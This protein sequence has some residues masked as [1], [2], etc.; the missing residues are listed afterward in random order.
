MSRVNKE[1]LLKS[2]QR[3]LS[4]GQHQKALAEYR[5]ILDGWP[6]DD[7]IRLKIAELCERLGRC[8]EAIEEYH[9]VAR[10]FSDKGFYTRAIAVLTRVVSMNPS[11]KDVHLELAE[12]YQ[13]LGRI[14][15]SVRHYQRAA[16]IEQR[17][18]EKRQSIDILRKISDLEPANVDKR[19]EVAALYYK[20][21]FDDSGYERYVETISE[22]APDSQELLEVTQ[23]MFKVA[24]R[25]HRLRLKLAEVHLARKEPK[26]ALEVLDA[27]IGDQRT[28]RTVE[29]MAKAKGDAEETEDA[30]K[31]L[32]EAIELYKSD[33]NPAKRRELTARLVELSA[34][35]APAEGVSAGGGSAPAEVAPPAS[36]ES[37]DDSPADDGPAGETPEPAPPAAQAEEAAPPPVPAQAPEDEAPPLVI[38]GDELSLPADSGP[39]EGMSEDRHLDVELSGADVAFRHGN[40]AAAIAALENVARLYPHRS[41]PLFRLL[42]IHDHSEDWVGVA[43]LSR[44]IGALMEKRGDAARAARYYAEASAAEAHLREAEGDAPEKSAAEAAPPEPEPESVQPPQINIVID[45]GEVIQRHPAPAG[46]RPATPAGAGPPA[47]A[48]VAGGPDARS[49]ASRELRQLVNENV[50]AK[51]RKVMEKTVLSTAFRHALT[52][53]PIRALFIDRLDQALTRA[54]R[55]PTYKFAVLVLDLDRFKLVN[56]GLGHAVG[57]ELLVAIARRLEETLRKGNTAAYLGGDE[58]TILLDEVRDASDAVRIADQIK[59]RLAMP[60]NLAGQDVFTSASIG[61]ALSDDLYERAEELLRDADTAMY[62]A[63][64]QGKARYEVFDQAMHA[65]AMTLL[66]LETD[67][68]RAL[69]RGE[70]RVHFQPIVSLASGKITGFEALARWQHPSGK[71]TPPDE[72]IP[73]AEEIALIIPIDRWV[74]SEACRQLK[75]WQKRFPDDP[76]LTMNVN[77]SGKHFAQSDLMDHIRQVLEEMHV[78]PETLKLEI[79]ESVVMENVDEAHAILTGL[80][81][82]KVK[83]NV[84]D[85]GTG[86]SS[87]AAL[88]RFPFDALKID[89]AFVEGVKDKGENEEIVKTIISLGKNLGMSI[90]AEGIETPEQFSRLRN[91]GCDYGQ[92][93]LFSRGLTADDATRLLERDPIW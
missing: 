69:D 9:R 48:C 90:V 49:A 86:H 46:A 23:R 27:A 22:L 32:E 43:H 91:L 60:F 70:F 35:P 84:D 34:P 59:N 28:A 17:K 58:F 72:F 53:L 81:K 12:L 31:L 36:A 3:H 65:R 8:D 92:G 52:G 29:L 2:V 25:D 55:D 80:K 77:L 68:R 79:T 44:R 19:L 74:L 76:P 61:I 37:G 63:K 4:K 78:T 56:D 62:R 83:L 18:G 82:L 85:F 50:S 38:P 71:L 64:A 93:F 14:A 42:W 57:D 40:R 13:K 47:P 66:E 15:E 21:G 41:D 10:R 16:S 67:L 89:R 1:K 20:D 5:K 6:Q 54:K 33:W 7:T 88:H 24:P 11:L 73:L 45:D 39:P 51:E 87:L 75:V 26:L 30:K